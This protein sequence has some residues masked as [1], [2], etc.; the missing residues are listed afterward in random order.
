MSRFSQVREVTGGYKSKFS[1]QGE[2][3]YSKYLTTQAIARLGT[4]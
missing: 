3:V 1:E 2:D 4:G